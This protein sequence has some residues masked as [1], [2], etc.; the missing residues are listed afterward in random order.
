MVG[1]GIRGELTMSHRTGSAAR[2]S[3]AVDTKRRP[4]DVAIIGAGIAGLYCGYK[5]G[6]TG[7]KFLIAEQSTHLGGRIW[8]TRILEQGGWLNDDVAWTE[9]SSAN[10]EF[11]AEFGPM[12]LELDLQE[13]LHELLDELE[14]GPEDLEKFPPYDSPISTHDPKYEM[15]GEETEQ[16]T[17]FDLLK[18]AVLRI[19]GKIS[20]VETSP[21]SGATDLNKK[22]KELFESLTKASVSRQPSWQEPFLEWIK[23][24][25]EHDYQNLRQFGIFDDGTKSGTALWNM[26]FWNLLSEVLSHH[27]VMRIRDL[28][29]FYHLIPENPN[30]AE[31]LIFWLRCLRTSEDMVGIRGGMQRITEKIVAKVGKSKIKTG[32]KLIALDRAED[33]NIDLTFANGE[34]WRARRVILALPKAPLEEL[35]GLNAGKFYRE[36]SDDLDSVFSFPMLKLFLEVKEKFWDQDRTRTNKYATVVPSREI[37]YKS[38][39]LKSSKRGLILLY[40]DRPASSFWANYVTKLG[41]QEAPELGGP[42]DNER[43][44]NKAVQYL[45]QHGV[46]NVKSEDIPFYGIRDWGRKPYD[47]ANHSWRPERRSWEVLK[48]LSGFRLGSPTHPTGLET[49]VHICGEAYSDYHGFIEGSLRSAGHVLH[50]IDRKFG[51]ST[52]WLCDDSKCKHRPPAS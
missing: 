14:F 4:L 3:K 24:L 32:Y 52:E 31:W 26:G 6:E 10:V 37:H 8:T 28:G 38:S 33:E 43:V 51:T 30:A 40:T 13:K 50:R 45:K 36:F 42:A 34:H 21:T 39:L 7:L 18:L 22:L 2:T 47:G 20:V 5:L 16:L 25:G 11:C 12:R 29:T 27:A 49:D 44:I 41:A 17:P 15:T 1:L 46:D 23:T 19:F 9:K 35:A 48:R